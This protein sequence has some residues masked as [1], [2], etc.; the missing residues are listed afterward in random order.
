MC[1]AAGSRWLGFHRAAPGARPPV[2]RAGELR[3]NTNTFSVC[4]PNRNK[5]QLNG[6]M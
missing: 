5:Q 4:H 6:G 3:H 2:L 1:P